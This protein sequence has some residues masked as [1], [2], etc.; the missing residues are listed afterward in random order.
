VL[1]AV[2]QFDVESQF[3]VTRR[4][5]TTES[6]AGDEN[7]K[8]L[9]QSRHQIRGRRLC[10]ACRLSEQLMHIGGSHFRLDIRVLVRRVIQ[11]RLSKAV[12]P[13]IDV[14][15]HT[16]NLL[17]CVISIGSVVINDTDAL[18]CI[19]A[20]DEFECTRLANGY[21]ACRLHL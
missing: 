14:E 21:L 16:C 5:W 2:R 3:P 17:A 13:G 18:R 6:L 7:L 11:R 4:L 9:L 15:I 10:D 12:G 8:E 1:K 20:K 19:V